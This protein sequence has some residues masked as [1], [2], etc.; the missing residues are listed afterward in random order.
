MDYRDGS[1]VL[2]CI[3]GGPCGDFLVVIKRERCFPLKTL[4]MMPIIA[5][6]P[7]I[8]QNDLKTGMENL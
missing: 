5:P 4:Q 1:Y 7:F 2:L 3:S 6:T 8:S